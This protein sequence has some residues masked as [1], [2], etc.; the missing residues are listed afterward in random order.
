MKGR[1]HSEF[2]PE[3][4]IRYDGIYKVVKY[5][6]EKGKSGFIVWKYL[7]RRDDS[8]PAPWTEEGKK[9]I[10][11]EGLQIIYPDGYLEAKAEKE[12]KKRTRSQDEEGDED[13]FDDDQEEETM[14]PKS[15][16]Q[17]AS[18]KMS[19]E[20]LE[21]IDK[22]EENKNLWDQVKSKESANKKELLEYIEE[23]FCCI[24]CQDIA[25][26]PI[27]TSCHHNFCKGCMLMSFQASDDPKKKI[28]PSCRH[29]LGEKYKL[30]VN[31]NLKDA[32]NLMFPGYEAGR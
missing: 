6:P 12:G 31:T 14:P 30:D 28:C 11:E 9:R 22:D 32:L 20:W 16:K 4:G 3:E 23:L 27:T 8:E 18:Y 26:Q 15:K 10:E 2:A 7:F 13:F 21:A 29:D 1:K 17:K 24:I 19:Q 5:W 25:F